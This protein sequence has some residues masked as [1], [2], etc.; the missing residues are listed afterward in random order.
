MARAH[1]DDP[2]SSAYKEGRIP[3]KNLS[4]DEAQDTEDAKPHPLRAYHDVIREHQG[5]VEAPAHWSGGTWR[6]HT[7]EGSNIHYYTKSGGHEVQ[8]RYNK[9]KRKVTGHNVALHSSN[10]QYD[11][12]RSSPAKLREHLRKADEYQGDK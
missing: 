10:K 12:S 5:G 6:K 11:V 1:V 3:T 8:L 7:P 2:G 4:C 9:A